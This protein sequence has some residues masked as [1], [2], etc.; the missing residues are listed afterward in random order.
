MLSKDKYSFIELIYN[1]VSD[2]RHINQLA[3]NKITG[4]TDPTNTYNYRN[5]PI[6]HT[7]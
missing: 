2:N 6:E 5:S 1:F 4:E 7:H 3:W